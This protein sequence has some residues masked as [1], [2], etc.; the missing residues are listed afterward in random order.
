MED[1]G[2]A[3]CCRYS[4]I[5]NRLHYCGPSEANLHLK[6]YITSGKDKEKV[7][8][9]LKNFEGLYPYLQAIAEKHGLNPFDHKVVEGYWHGN[10]LLDSFDKDDIK[11][12][13][14]S[15]T[16]RGLLPSMAKKLIEKL[17]QGFVPHHSFN[18]FY[19]GVGMITGS[20]LTNAQNMDNCKVSFGVVKEIKG[21]RLIVEYEPLLK[22][23]NNKL[24]FGK[25]ISKE[26][27][28]DALFIKDLKPGDIVSFHWGFAAGIID[29]R[30][31]ENIRKYTE[32]N[33][34]VFNSLV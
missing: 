9:S 8:E 16:K 18:V 17:P 30:T 15:L 14:M 11:N 10:E 5:T 7:I 6:E 26:I 3:L 13:I 4:Y 2:L 12:L 28:Y 21:D 31:K 29:N 22:D 25:K 19:V 33:L 1:D 32:N 27:D 23:K 34:R 20:V 24:F